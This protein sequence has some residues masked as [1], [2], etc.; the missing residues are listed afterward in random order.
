MEAVFSVLNAVWPY[1][2]AVLVFLVLIIIHEFGHFLAAKLLG[3]R[4]NEFA[5]GFGPKLFS[6]QGKETLYRLNAIPFGG[7]CAME[8]EDE[9][10]SDPRAFC[11]QKAWKRL[12]I[13]AMGA[14]FNLILGLALVAVTLS[15]FSLLPTTTVARFN[16][17]AISQQSGLQ[18]DDRI[19]E[20][21]GRPIDTSIDLSYAF[22]GVPDG[23]VDMVVIRNGKR[24]VLNDVL[25]RTQTDNGV[26]YVDMD[27]YI[28]GRPKTVGS[29]ITQTFKTTVSY[30]RVI[31]YSLIDLLSGKYGVSAVSGPVGVTATIGQIARKRLLDLFPVM[32]LITVNLGIFNLLPLPALDGGRIFFILVEMMIRRPV[33]KKYEGIIHAVGLVILLILMALIT[34]K[35]IWSLFT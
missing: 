9:G 15:T 12:I 30:V 33:P 2:V 10:S 27:F 8:G 29:M 7:Y 20:I 32:A 26:A 34:F 24:T 4:V 3:V 18:V 22:T 28:Y 21:D 5:V 11:N 13:T 16:E 1:A 35:D 14:I 31:W 19:I 25:F 6:H 23:K 17:N